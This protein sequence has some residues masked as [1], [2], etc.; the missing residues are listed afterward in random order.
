MIGLIPRRIDSSDCGLKSLWSCLNKLFYFFSRKLPTFIWKSEEICINVKEFF[1]NGLSDWL[2]PV[3]IAPLSVYIFGV[4]SRRSW[5]KYCN[6]GG[7]RSLNPSLFLCHFGFFSVAI[8]YARFCEAQL[9]LCVLSDEN[10]PSQKSNTK[11]LPHWNLGAKNGYT[12]GGNESF[13]I[14]VDKIVKDR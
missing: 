12:K 10:T 3:V 14:C 13:S 8:V 9:C 5:L 1:L 7:K 4:V 6:N 11:L 2:L